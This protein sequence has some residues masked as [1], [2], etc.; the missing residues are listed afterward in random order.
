MQVHL[1]WALLVQVI[2]HSSGLSSFS[3]WCLDPLLLYCS[4]ICCFLYFGVVH[5]LVVPCFC[6][7]ALEIWKGKAKI[8]LVVPVVLQTQTQLFCWLYCWWYLFKTWWFVF[9]YLD[10]FSCASL[11][12]LICDLWIL[13]DFLMILNLCLINYFVVW[14]KCFFFFLF[15][16]ILH[17]L[18]IYMKLY[19]RAHT[20]VLWIL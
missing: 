6:F 13:Y 19:A 4:I 1:L 2:L 18:C 3:S 11:N 5:L 7:A 15:A 16:A 12:C 8:V 14:F 10:L 20:L 9:A 17:A